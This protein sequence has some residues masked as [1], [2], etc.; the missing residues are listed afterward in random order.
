MR[1]N[2]SSILSPDDPHVMKGEQINIVDDLKYHG[3]YDGSKYNDFRVRIRLAWTLFL[4]AKSLLRSPKVK[5]N[6]KI[7][8]FKAACISI[9]YG[10]ESWILA[11]AFIDK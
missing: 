1:Q 3:S 5:P 6:F 2:Q 10:C 11:E 9:L 4:K 7:R 8:L